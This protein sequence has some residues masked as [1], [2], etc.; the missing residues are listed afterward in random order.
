MQPHGIWV[1]RVKRQ[2]SQFSGVD[3]TVDDFE[4]SAVGVTLARPHMRFSAMNVFAYN[5]R[6]VARGH[7]AMTTQPAPNDVAI[8]VV[9]GR[10]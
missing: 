2:Q 10:W 9:L 5:E 4:K 1:L 8:L 6:S 7:A 3:R